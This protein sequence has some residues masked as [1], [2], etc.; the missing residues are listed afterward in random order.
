MS[1][2]W[3]S[4]PITAIQLNKRIHFNGEKNDVYIQPVIVIKWLDVQKSRGK[5]FPATHL[6]P[7]DNMNNVPQ[8]KGQLENHLLLKH[9]LQSSHVLTTTKIP[10]IPY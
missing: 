1:D 9:H 2:Q 6:W 4:T 8:N 10:S 7:P 3:H 5:I